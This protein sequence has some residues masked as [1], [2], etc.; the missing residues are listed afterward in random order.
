[1]VARRQDQAWA[2]GQVRRLERLTGAKLRTA[3]GVATWL[4]E[5][6]PDLINPLLSAADS[7][8]KVGATLPEDA[9]PLGL[10]C[11]VNGRY[12]LNHIGSEIIEAIRSQL[13]AEDI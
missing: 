1:M 2:M 13:R 12:V 8:D 3:D 11:Y 4:R 6:R 5:N 7:E 9:K 10:G